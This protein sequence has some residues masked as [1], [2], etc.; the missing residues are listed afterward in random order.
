[1]IVLAG[2]AMMFIGCFVAGVR[3][4]DVPNITGLSAENFSNNWYGIDTISFSTAIGI[5]YPA[6]TGIMA[7]VNRSGELKVFLCFKREN[8]IFL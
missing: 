8:H 1:M 6:V 7:G 2:I 4:L 3:E 5:C